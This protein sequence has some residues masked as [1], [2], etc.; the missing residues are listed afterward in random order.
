MISRVHMIGIDTINT[1]KTIHGT[2]T[3][4]SQNLHYQ[5]DWETKTLHGTESTYS[6]NRYDQHDAESTHSRSWHN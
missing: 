5:H 4:Y 3:T 2:K 6:R 1:T